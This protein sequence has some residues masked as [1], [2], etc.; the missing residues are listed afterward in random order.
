MGKPRFGM[1]GDVGFKVFPI[2]VVITDFFAGHANGEN[3]FQDLNT[4]EGLFSLISEFVLIKPEYG[5]CPDSKQGQTTVC[6]NFPIR[7]VNS[8]R[9]EKP[10][11]GEE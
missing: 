8:W 7:E 2:P 6:Q 9:I 10:N 4:P 3:P 5:D 1:L 11:D